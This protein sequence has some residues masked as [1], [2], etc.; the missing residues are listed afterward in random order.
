MTEIMK[1]VWASE[2]YAGWI[3]SILLNRFELY[4]DDAAAFIDSACEKALTAYGN[5]K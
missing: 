4:G 2:E 5:L 3:D 1:N